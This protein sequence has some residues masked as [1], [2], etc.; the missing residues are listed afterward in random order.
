MKLRKPV[1]FFILI[2]ML[3]AYFTKP[4]KQQF[5]DYIQPAV[6]KTNILPVVE[7]QDRFLYVTVTATYVDTVNTTR[8]NGHVVAAGFKEDYIGVFTKFWKWNQ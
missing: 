3:M 7:Y 8:Q 5:L 4:T 1:T 2:A 6:S